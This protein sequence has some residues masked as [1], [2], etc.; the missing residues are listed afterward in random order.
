VRRALAIAAALVLAAPAGA[1]A[2]T[3]GQE[4]EPVVGGGSFANAPLL[5]PGSYR[6]TILP[7]ERLFYG[8]RLEPGQQLRMRAKLDVEPGEVDTDTAA[9]FSIGLQTPLREVI[10]DTD[11]DLSGNSTVGSVEDEFDV[12]FPPAVAPSA[13]RDGIG[14][15]RGPGIRY[16]SLYLSSTLRKPAK[17]EFPVEFELEVVGDP[18]PDATPEPTPGKEATPAPENDEEAEGDGASAGAIAGIGLLGLLAGLLG[19]GL[20]ARRRS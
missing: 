3:A 11:E 2:Q 6:D 13:T 4:P 9:G 10:T 8:V 5:E 18:Q 14:D 1:G 19:G 17:A 20:A 7:G 12:V 16:P 15:Y